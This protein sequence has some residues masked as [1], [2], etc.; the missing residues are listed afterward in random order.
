[1]STF[2]VSDFKV[3]DFIKTTNHWGVVTQVTKLTVWY[4][5][6]NGMKRDGT[7]VSPDLIVGKVTREAFRHHE[8]R[9]T[10]WGSHLLVF[11]PAPK[12]DWIESAV[13]E[14]CAI[15]A[16]AQTEYENTFGGETHSWISRDKM[17]KVIRKH[18]PK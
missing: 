14:I 11:P 17:L 4:D 3:G 16:A 13:K 15:E 2:K 6:H 18:A 7:G 8:R 10:S 1:M 5:Y 12:V 9:N